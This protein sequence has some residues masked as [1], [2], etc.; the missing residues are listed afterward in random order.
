MGSARVLTTTT[1]GNVNTLAS[2]AEGLHTTMKSSA[3]DI[4]TDYTRYRPL[5]VEDTL[6]VSRCE[7]LMRKAHVKLMLVVDHDDHLL[8]MVDLADLMGPRLHKLVGQ[9]RP[10]QELTVHDVMTARDDLAAIDYRALASATMADLVETLKHE[11]R[12]HVL[13][14]D[15]ERGEIRGV[16]AAS[17][18][19]RSLDVPVDITYAPSFADICHATMEHMRKVSAA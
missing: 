3:L 13:V 10:K 8:G 2:P 6:A 15:D 19:A 16:L 9:H 18:I 12:L 14:V 11:H 4:L 7:E 5:V 17:D 1:L